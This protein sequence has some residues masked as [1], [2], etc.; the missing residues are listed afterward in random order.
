MLQC[1]RRTGRARVGLDAKVVER[2]RIGVKG[3]EL[4]EQGVHGWRKVGLRAGGR[5]GAD[6]PGNV[7]T[8]RVLQ[9]WVPA[10]AVCA[11]WRVGWPL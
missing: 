9:L 10:A 8:E 6:A 5:A 3:L 1:G 11:S 4:A 2:L 7:K